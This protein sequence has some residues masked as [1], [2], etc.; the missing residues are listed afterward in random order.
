M[1][2]TRAQ[3]RMSQ[4]THRPCA[5]QNVRARVARIAEMAPFGNSCFERRSRNQYP[6][7]GGRRRV[8]ASHCWT[9]GGHSAGGW[10]RCGGKT[11]CRSGVA[12]Q[13]GS[14]LLATAPSLSSLRSR[15]GRWV[16]S[17]PSLGLTRC[18]HALDIPPHKNTLIG[19]VLADV[20]GKPRDAPAITANYFS[21]PTQIT[22]PTG[23]VGEIPESELDNG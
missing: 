21:L 11:R 7:A 8:S 19:A 1:C 14:S 22:E 18:S 17:D 20:S 4:H 6:F 5:E 16:T 12:P 9:E 10:G 2:K 15:V 13:T 3:L 23:V